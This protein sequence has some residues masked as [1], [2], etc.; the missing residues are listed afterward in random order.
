MNPKIDAHPEAERLLAFSL[1]GLSPEDSAV[2]EKHL[3]G[4]RSCCEALA[5][6]GDRDEF[7][8]LIK[9]VGPPQRANPWPVVTNSPSRFPD[10]PPE[11]REHP[12]YRIVGAL[13]TG[14]MGAVYAA[15]H[16]LLKRTVV[17]KV[18][19]PELLRDAEL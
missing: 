13:G 15:E 9:T 3:A 16:R 5:S 2:V 19:R 18:L 10:V 1:G 8:A 7:L 6:M 12:R 4:C 11:L 14:G 17:V